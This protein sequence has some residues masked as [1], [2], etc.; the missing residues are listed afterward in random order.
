L[1]YEKN[2]EDNKLISEKQKENNNENN[3]NKNNSNNNFYD[4]NNEYI[5]INYEEFL[6]AESDIEGIFS[7]LIFYLWYII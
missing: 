5:N 6:S 1:N 3:L 7:I 2:A 4:K